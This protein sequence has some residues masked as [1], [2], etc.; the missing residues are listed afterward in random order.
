MSSRCHPGQLGNLI[1]RAWHHRL[2]SAS[3]SR[4]FSK[5]DSSALRLRQQPYRQ[6]WPL[7]T[8]F[9]MH[10]IRP[11]DGAPMALERSAGA[12]PAETDSTGQR[13]RLPHRAPQTAELN[14]GVRGHKV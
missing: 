5:Q 7:P 11:H 12:I 1:R 4:E 13:A 3:R 9:P 2:E 10:G 6:S 8:V 14:V